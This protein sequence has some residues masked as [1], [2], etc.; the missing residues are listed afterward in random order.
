MKSPELLKN[1]PTPIHKVWRPML[2]ISLVLHGIVL[3]LPVPSNW[4]T[5]EPEEQVKVTQLPLLSPS[6]K[7]SVNSTEEPKPKT[8]PTPSQPTPFVSAS[9]SQPAINPF[10]YSIQPTPTLSPTFEPSLSIAPSPSISVDP[11]PSPSPSPSESHC[12]N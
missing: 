5:S 2:L 9:P 12:E 11:K 10:D 6:P 3:I 1:L 4:E 8:S 7:S